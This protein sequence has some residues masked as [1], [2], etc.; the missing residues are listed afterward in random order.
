MLRFDMDAL[1]IQE[2]SQTDYVSQTP[3]VMHAC[4][5]DAHTAIGLGIAQLLAQHRDE[6]A[7]DDEVCVSARRRRL[8]RRAGDDRRSACWRIQSRKWRWV[9]TSGTISPVGLVAAGNGGVMAAADIFTI[10]VQGKGGHGAQ[11]HLCVD[12]VLIASQIVVALQSIVARN[13]NPRQ[14]AVVTVGAIHAGMAFNIIADTAELTGTI[15]TFDAATR[16]QIVR[17]MTERRREYR[18]GFGRRAPRSRSRSS[19]PRRS[20]TSAWRSWC[21][22]RRAMCWARSTSQPIN[23]R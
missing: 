18:A 13:V 6:M 4:G 8:R 12:A 23:S 10:K 2:A 21:A 14:T 16:E 15:R 5:H 11:P 1:P 3:G 20:T 22:R 7:G 17:R 9:C 19:R